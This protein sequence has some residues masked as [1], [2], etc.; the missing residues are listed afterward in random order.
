MPENQEWKLKA[1]EVEKKLNLKWYQNEDGY[2]DGDVESDI[3][4][5]IG[6]N[7]EEDYLKV[8]E[9]N[10]SWP[11]FYHLSSIRKN[12]LNWYPFREAASVLEIGCGCGAIT[13]LLCER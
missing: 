12:L 13:E 5:Y 1:E 3:I 8:I 11:V 6:Q 10:F 9:E 2:S 7:K 4:K